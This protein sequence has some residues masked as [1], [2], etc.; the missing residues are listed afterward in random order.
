VAVIGQAMRP[1]LDIAVNQPAQEPGTAA[2]PSG[3]GSAVVAAG[4]PRGGES[5]R[6][7][8]G[9]GRAAR[10]FEF[11]NEDNI[12][13]LGVI[14]KN[15][16]FENI[17]IAVSYMKPKDVSYVLANL[18]PAKRSAVA[19][20]LVNP[21]ETS[22]EELEK[23][24]KAIKN[25]MEYM[26]GGSE[27]ML[28]VLDLADDATRELLLADVSA[29]NPRIADQLRHELFLF[30]D[31]VKLSDTEIRK[32]VDSLDNETLSVALKE[33]PEPIVSK[34]LVN[35]SAGAQANLK[36]M[37]ELMGA[38]PPNKVTEARNTMVSIIRKLI[39]EGAIAP[40]SQEQKT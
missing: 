34:F 25:K 39:N 2:A 26:V 32:L 6:A 38:Q 28:G 22:F 4:A 9:T 3:R 8:A 18:E 12:K 31:I 15:E 17:S 19:N 20:R 40:K 33:A 13:R 5:R 21:G 29:Q 30:S 36:Q 24:E 14:L 7:F 16:P 23:V 35:I 11:I 10:R 37:M 1:K 27:F